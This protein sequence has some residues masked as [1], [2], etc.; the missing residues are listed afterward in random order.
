MRNSEVLRR[1]VLFVDLDGANVQQAA[2]EVGTTL[3][4]SRV[5]VDRGKCSATKSDGGIERL[6]PLVGVP[7]LG[8]A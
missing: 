7:N 8:T 4:L 6:P 1:N 2:V 5:V 3:C